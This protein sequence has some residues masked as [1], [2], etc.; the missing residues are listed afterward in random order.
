MSN[1]FTTTD[2]AIAKAFDEM[3]DT[4]H[5]GMSAS[6]VLDKIYSRAK[7]IDAETRIPE[8]VVPPYVS[9]MQAIADDLR[10]GT[11]VGSAPPLT[12]PDLWLETHKGKKG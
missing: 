6:D 5:S 12:G 4:N 3:M 1:S 10:G 2:A 11:F 8:T 7:E 9:P